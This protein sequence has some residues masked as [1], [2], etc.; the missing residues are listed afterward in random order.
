MSTFKYVR[1]KWM[2]GSQH[3]GE[4]CMA[5]HFVRHNLA[6]VRRKQSLFTSCWKPCYP[7]AVPAVASDTEQQ[8]NNNNNNNPAY[9]FWKMHNN[10]KIEIGH[11]KLQTRRNLINI[12]ADK[13]QKPCSSVQS[14]DWLPHAPF[15]LKSGTEDCLPNTFSFSTPWLRWLKFSSSFISAALENTWN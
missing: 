12:F 4:T 9:G 2:Q 13:A 10:A 6:Q 1:K 15:C 5:L 11:C 3:F 8:K 7:H 14:L